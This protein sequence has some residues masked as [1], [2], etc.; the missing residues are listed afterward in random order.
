M[1]IRYDG[2][3]G[4]TPLVLS[5]VQGDAG[6]WAI[7]QEME[8]GADDEIQVRT[9][10]GV[11]GVNAIEHLLSA[12]PEFVDAATGKN[13]LLTCS[14]CGAPATSTMFVD[15]KTMEQVRYETADG[16]PACIHCFLV[17]HPQYVEY[18]EKF[19]VD[20]AAAEM[21]R[22]AKVTIGERELALTAAAPAPTATLS[23]PPTSENAPFCVASATAIATVLVPC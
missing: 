22:K 16:K 5:G 12:G 3:R 11:F 8:F 21:V 20:P 18:H 23:P 17:D 6:T 2:R 4:I 13:P 7:G 19:A 15:P 1:K 10:A 14:V 9:P